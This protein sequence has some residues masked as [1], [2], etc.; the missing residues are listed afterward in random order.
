[1]FCDGRERTTVNIGRRRPDEQVNIYFFD[2]INNPNFESKIV[3]V[4]GYNIIAILC[5]FNMTMHS[6]RYAA[7][8]WK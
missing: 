7:D 4:K 3:L 2:F 1:M 8:V 6:R 5:S